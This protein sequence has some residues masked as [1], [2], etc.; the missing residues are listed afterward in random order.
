MT[1]AELYEWGILRSWSQA[2][3]SAL[4]SMLS[5]YVILPADDNTCRR[6]AIVRDDR[7]TQPISVD[8]AWIAASALTQ[9]AA[10]VTHNPRDFQGIIGLTVISEAP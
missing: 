4:Q 7:R 10:L 1:V 2:R 9:N 3:W 5:G 6:W 8:D